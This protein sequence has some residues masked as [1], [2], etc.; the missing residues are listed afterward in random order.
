MDSFAPME[1]LLEQAE[2]MLSKNAE[3]ID[4]SIV[5]MYF[6]S[7]QQ[8]YMV[9]KHNREN[10][11]SAVHIDATGAWQEAPV[12]NKDSDEENT[13]DEVAD[14]HEGLCEYE[15]ER[16]NRMRENAALAA[17]LEIQPVSET[18]MM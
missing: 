2:E 11:E 15:I 16:L 5:A 10:P 18:L 17:S 7:Q 9:N 8:S 1:G 4:Q 13:S 14:P 3:W 6:Q 12:D